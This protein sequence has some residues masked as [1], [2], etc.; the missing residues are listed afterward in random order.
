V[1]TDGLYSS[2][3]QPAVV[4]GIVVSEADSASVHI[5]E[6]LREVT[7]WTPRLDESR[8]GSAGG[9][10]YWTTNGATLRVVEGLH[11]ECEGVASIFDDPDCIAFVSRHSGETGPLLSAHFTGNLGPAEF[12]GV[13]GQL[14]EA[15]PGAADSVLQSLQRHAPSGYEIS[16]ECTHHGPSDVGVPSLFVEVGSDEDAWTD[17][18][19]ATAAARATLA[20]RDVDVQ[21]D[22]TVAC[23]G[24]G[25]Y[26]PRATRIAT[27]TDWAVGHV[28]ADWALEQMGDATKVLGQLFERSNATRAIVDGDHPEYRR[29]IESRGYRVVSETWLR[30]TRGIPA[31]RVEALE[32]ALG[33]VGDGLRFGA[34]ASRSDTWIIDEIPIGFLEACQAVDRGATVEVVG[35]HTMAY[36]TTE[37]GN[38]LTGELA[39]PRRPTRSALIDELVDVLDLGAASVQREG[40]TVL[41]TQMQ[42]DPELARERGVPEGPAFGTLADGEPVTVDGETIEPETVRREETR[43]FEL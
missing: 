6:R 13:S 4:L 36:M 3:R 43:R 11:L 26:A 7:D 18:A 37:S 28:A 12:G 2:P 29:V 15:A 35:E 41:M 20:I 10:R 17:P 40:D 23:V 27:E 5:G 38:R 19:A 32:E 9:G 34:A 8:P 1:P 16:M 21:P 33:T 24:G 39:L 25:H 42:F 22:R 31:E 14:A 30:E